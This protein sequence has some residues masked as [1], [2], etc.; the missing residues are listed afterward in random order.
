M[1][2][3]R[4]DLRIVAPEADRLSYAP[5]GVVNATDVQAAIDNLAATVAVNSTQPPKI[6]ATS[7]NFAQSPYAVLGTDFI[8]EVDT[9]GGVVV[10][11]PQAVAARSQPLEIK[12]ISLNAGTNNIQIT[13]PIEGL[14]PYLINADGESITIR[15][16]KAKTAYEV[17]AW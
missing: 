1:T 14:N 6:A 17:V 10:I 13:G 5:V 7:V 12:D 15:P 2:R 3:I 11:T 8:L 4:T 9:T 16:N